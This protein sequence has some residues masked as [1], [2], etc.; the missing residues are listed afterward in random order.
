M[1]D[2]FVHNTR[3]VF[4]PGVHTHPDQYCAAKYGADVAVIDTE[5]ELRAVSDQLHLLGTIHQL[6]GAAE[7]WIGGKTQVPANQRVTDLGDVINEGV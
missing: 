6:S 1:H 4:V 7:M 5:Q 2:F 3:Y